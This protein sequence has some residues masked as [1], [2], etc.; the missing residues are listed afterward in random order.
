MLSKLQYPKDLKW[1]EDKIKCCP[2]P[3]RQ[4]PPPASQDPDCCYNA[5][6]H[7]L[8][9]VNGRLNETNN[10]LDH[11]GKQLTVA[12]ERLNRLSTWNTELVTA[13]DLARKI[14]HQ[15]EVI[16]HQLEIICRNTDS[17]SRAIEV[18]ICM[19]R[20]FYVTVDVLQSKY[21]RLITC[22]KCL[23]N[24]ALTVT[25][26]I[27]KCLS[28]FGAALAAVTAQR[29]TLIQ[30]VMLVYSISVGLHEQICDDYGYRRLTRIWQDTL[31]CKSWCDEGVWGFDPK[32][33]GAKPND[34][35]DPFCQT[36]ILRMPLCNEEYVTEINFLY[37]EE[38]AWVKVLTERQT[39]LTRDKNHLTIVQTGLTNAIKE[40][41]PSVRCS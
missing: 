31:G 40:V 35:P 14:C 18:L 25:T 11:L 36:P 28:D 24:P 37:E 10:A 16:S 41:Q 20:E 5:W 6:Q 17:T 22:I 29:D 8:C 2:P 9:I 15:L 33:P 13:N 1:D 34:M 26:G 3:Q 4:T 7:E 27:G 30:Q 12:T 32:R 21:D 19:F 38:K 39:V 23:N